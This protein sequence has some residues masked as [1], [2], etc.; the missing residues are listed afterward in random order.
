MSSPSAK[1]AR[2]SLSKS[3]GM[4]T[5]DAGHNPNIMELIL[6]DEKLQFEFPRPPRSTIKASTHSK[7]DE[8]PDSDVEPFF[9]DGDGDGSAT[10]QEGKNF[11]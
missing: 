4:A 10:W 11:G 1:R 8:S 7:H 6:Q 5:T 9:L 3:D 2:M